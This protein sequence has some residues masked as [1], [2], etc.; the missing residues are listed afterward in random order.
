MIYYNIV[1]QACYRALTS[2]RGSWES[3]KFRF[4]V[5]HVW[6]RLYVMLG[7]EGSVVDTV[8]LVVCQ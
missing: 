4:W 5:L 2:L 7:S 8:F 3:F 1:N 6:F